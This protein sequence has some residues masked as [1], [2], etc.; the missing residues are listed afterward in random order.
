MR[1]IPSGRRGSL[2]RFC[3]GAVLVIGCVAA[4]TAVGGLLQVQSIVNDLK[5]TKPI[6][7]LHLQLPAPGDPETILVVGS[8]HRAGE[9]FKDSNTDTM[10]LVRLNAGSSTINVLSV[11]RDLQ[12]TIDG[13]TEK[14]NAAYS[15]GGTPL[16]I[17]T[18]QQQVFPGLVVN[19]VVDVNFSGFE[20]LVDAIGCVYGDVDH[21]YYNNTNYS[22]YSSID[23]QPGYQK[24]CDTNALAFVRFR[25][26]DSDI[27]RNARQ[28]DFIRW[29]KDDYSIN[30]LLSNKDK[31][32]RIFGKHAQVDSGLQSLDGLISLFDLVINSD[33]H[34]I[35]SIPFPY[36][37]G[38]CGGSA[39][40][41]CYVFAQSAAAESAA[42]RQFMTPTVAPSSAPA[43]GAA[44]S[45]HR[46]HSGNS[47]TAGLT[48]DPGDGHSQS[49]QLGHIAI[50]VYY[51]KLILGSSQ[52]CFAITGNCD[53]TYP[54][55][56]YNKSYPRNYQVHAQNGTPYAAYRFTLVI[57][58]SLGLYYGVQGLA[59]RNP[60][61]LNRPTQIQTIDGKRLMEYFNGGK[62]SIVA[63]RTP[64]AVYWVSNT[65]TDAI[66][67]HQL[68][69][70]AASLTLFKG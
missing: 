40:T 26:T 49:G 13:G 69:G 58:A 9:P 35:K 53:V 1:L 52:Y 8:D 24:L 20:D 18:M 32:L 6:E 7:G 47:Y 44:G 3:A 51:P 61:I 54:N 70:I 17:K 28:Q 64:Q 21:R 19:H 29:A 50:P 12:V 31:L 5:L 15:L 63:W 38:P 22:D 30:Q 37:F 36:V 34:T 16:L 68:E 25:H 67:N 55:A 2:W 23:I 66:P 57:N 60:P 46:H 43:A 27:V 56:E 41:P 33:G 39:Q 59:W 14:L 10:M 4:T 48:A 11:P 65:L 45:R 42:Y 62:V